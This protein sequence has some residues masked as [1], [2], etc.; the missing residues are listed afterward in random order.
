VSDY[1]AL[2]L[3]LP[4]ALS[5]TLS[6]ARGSSLPSIRCV[7]AST[8]AGFPWLTIA[9]KTLTGWLV[10]GMD[11][12]LITAHSDKEGASPTFKKGYG[13]HPLGAWC[14][15]TQESLAMLLR[16]GNA[17][18]NTV[19]DHIEV[20][21]AALAQLPARWRS[22]LLIRI[23]GAG[24]SHDLVTHLLSLSTRRRTVLFTCGWM[25]TDADE[26]AIGC[27]RPARGPR[28]PAR[29]ARCR[30]TPQSLRSPA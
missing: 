27:S 14:S 16:P 2:C 9:G 1:V 15:N 19:S 12:T 24:A 20:L 5:L 3:P 17:G 10:P 21:A 8:A 29:T 30:R 4:G 28:P 6:L 18:S 13:F 22:K 26:Q 23:D 11:A 25:I 7:H